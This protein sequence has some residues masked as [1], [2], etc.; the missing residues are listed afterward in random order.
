MPSTQGEAKHCS[1]ECCPALEPVLQ[2]LAGA[3]AEAAGGGVG[4]GDEAVRVEGGSIA[5][6][7][8]GGRDGE[9]GDAAGV[10]SGRRVM[11]A[12]SAPTPAALKTAARPSTRSARW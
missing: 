8:R 10:E 7:G 5:D 4:V 9:A 1:R 2:G 12:P 11:P 6:A 3:G